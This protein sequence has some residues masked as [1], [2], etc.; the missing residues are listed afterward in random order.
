[1]TMRHCLKL[2]LT[3]AAAAATVPAEP[4]WQSERRAAVACERH[5]D[6]DIVMC[7]D[8]EDDAVTARWEIGSN[9]RILPTRDFV[10]CQDGLEL[11]NRCSAWSNRLFFDGYWG[12]WGYDAWRVFLPQTDFYLRWYQYVSD[13][14]SWGTLEDKSVMLHDPA[15]TITA[16]VATNREELPDVPNSGPGM[17]F[18]ANY[19]D[20][21]WPDTNGQ[22]TAVNRFQNQ[23]RNI[24]LI[25]G[26]WYVF[27][28]YIKLNIPGMSNGIARLWI[29]DASVA[30]D[31]QTLRLEYTDMRWLRK[32]DAGRRFGLLRLTVYHQRCDGSPNTCPPNG[33]EVLNQWH[34][35]DQI[36]ISTSPVGPA[37]PLRAL[38]DGP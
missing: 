29:D 30:I 31:E 8:F 15:N 7:E 6:P 18:V 17:P 4:A 22:Y 5:P 20:L 11:Q 28:W 10:Q 38:P 21:D 32:E 26:R 12:F 37:Q 27:E 36:V 1:M 9:R 16:Y 2:V 3:L 35:W 14:Y 23:G 24:T 34:R 25:P 13:P 33:P 19:Q